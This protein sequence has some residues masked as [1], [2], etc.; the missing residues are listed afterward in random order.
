MSIE[1]AVDCTFDMA[2]P[3]L[4]QVYDIM[5]ELSQDI[6]K[7]EDRIFV[8]N[9]SEEQYEPVQ[10]ALRAGMSQFRI[11]DNRT[12]TARIKY[13]GLTIEFNKVKSSEL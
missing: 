13:G 9:I 12:K 10:N 2:K 4:P 8:L 5:A 7:T 1:K 11:F 6:P 3:L